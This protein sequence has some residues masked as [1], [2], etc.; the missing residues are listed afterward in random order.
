MGQIGGDLTGRIRAADGVAGGA[1][2]VHEHISTCAGCPLRRLSGRPAHG[3]EPS[4]KRII[5]FGDDVERHVGVLQ[6]AEFRTLP[7]KHAGM[8]GLEPERG[9]IPRDQIAFALE[10]RNP[11]TVDHVA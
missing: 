9:R 4:F 10:I 11:E 1:P 3:R 2:G 7:A 5:R 6:A 8:I